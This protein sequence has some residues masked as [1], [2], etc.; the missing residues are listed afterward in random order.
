MSEHDKLIEALVASADPVKRVAPVGVRAALLIPAMLALGFAATTW[1][2]QA[3]GGWSV[4]DNNLAI[5]Y[6]LFSILIGATALVQALT[7]SIPGRVLRGA[8]WTMAAIAIWLG[9]AAINIESSSAIS[10]VSGER[11]FCF[12]FLMTA[13]LPMVAVAILALRRTAS[14]RP[15]PSLVAASGSVAFLSFGLLAFC[16]PPDISIADF[17]THL[18][19]ALVIGLLTVA[20]GRRLV[21]A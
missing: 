7:M 3:V 8:G 20:V 11:P 19:A 4:P 15:M 13:G 2:R 5:A 12:A 9:I 21:A 17:A 10:A 16:H 6:A 14:L 1:L 18:L